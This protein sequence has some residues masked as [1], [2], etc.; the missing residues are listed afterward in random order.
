MLT[1]CTSSDT[2]E[3]PVD[4]PVAAASSVSSIAS[5][6][7]SAAVVAS[8]AS[9][10]PASP[11]PVDSVD[12]IGPLEVPFIPQ[13]PFANWDALHEEACEEA[14]LLMLVHYEQKKPLSYEE[15]DNAIQ[16]LVAWEEQN[17][18]GVDIGMEEMEEIAFKKFGLKASARKEVTAETIMRALLAGHPV[19]IPAAGRDLGNPYFS[20]EG[21]WYHAIVIIGYKKGWFGEYFIVH[22]PGTKRGKNYEYAVDTLLNAVH[23]W[24][25]VKEEIRTGPRAMLVVEN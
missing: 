17:G 2:V 25:G 14:V 7:P 3:T 22:D 9:S 4:P 20:G 23:D 5:S 11:A 13:A 1:A 18:Y 16:E 6:E 24:T 21:P 12:M 10:A 15:G 19:I 8:V